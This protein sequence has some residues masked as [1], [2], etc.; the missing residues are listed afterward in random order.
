M[1][2]I[3]A[4]IDG[5][6]ELIKSL[7]KNDYKVRIGIIGS[8]AEAQHDNKSGLTNADIGSFHELGLGNNPERSFLLMPLV[9]K[10]PEEIAKMKK[11]IF[12]A[13]FRKQSPR[14]FYAQ[15]GAKALDII[16]NAFNTNGF[17][18]WT[19]LTARTTAAWEKKK[20]VAN[21]RTGTIAQFRKGLRIAGGRQILTDTG[22]LRH[23]ISFKVIKNV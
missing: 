7:K 11:E 16:E 13:I 6:Y 17:G 19:P 15:L 1:A 21:W 5:L 9:E 2:R 8:K 22:K 4:N 23:S 12:N 10:L 14:K 3:E 20:G 18:Q